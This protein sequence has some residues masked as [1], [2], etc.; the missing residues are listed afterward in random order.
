MQEHSCG[1][2]FFA[3]NR[4]VLRTYQRVASAMKKTWAR[5]KRFLKSNEAR[6]NAIAAV[7]LVVAFIAKDFVQER[8]KDFKD[9]LE[10]TQ[11]LMGLK[12]A[13]FEL[14]KQ[15][16]HL[17][18]AAVPDEEVVREKYFELENMKE[19]VEKMKLNADEQKWVDDVYRLNTDAEKDTAGVSDP[20]ARKELEVHWS[21]LVMQQ[22]QRAMFSIIP[23]ARK[24]LDQAETKYRWV[25]RFTYVL[26]S[27]SVLL[28]AIGKIFGLKGVE[29]S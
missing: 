28:A 17:G 13:L 25:R 19:L 18:K 7:T 23:D 15:I 8:V 11:N 26:S 16:E 5:L 14:E 6:L 21:E 1:V 2:L 20:M 9:S 22:I 24:Q 3:A 12:E 10:A 29:G 27:I 4:N